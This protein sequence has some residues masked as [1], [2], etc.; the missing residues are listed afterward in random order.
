MSE[1]TR[2]TGGANPDTPGPPAARPFRGFDVERATYARLKPGLVARAEGQFVAVVGKE[3]V[4][5]VKTSD[6]AEAEG[7]KRFGIGPLYIKRVTAEESVAEISRDV[8]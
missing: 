6:E 1:S 2:I 3:Y 8:L 4:G 7:Y 5:P